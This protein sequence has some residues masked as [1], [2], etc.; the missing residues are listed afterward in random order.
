MQFQASTLLSILSVLALAAAQSSSVPVT[1][2]AGF[3]PNPS[4]S[5]PASSTPATTSTATAT[6]AASSDASSAS[7]AT[8]S[9]SSG[10]A[11]APTAALLD[12]GVVVG[13]VGLAGMML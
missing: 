12:T 10:A 8:S 5:A 4:S 2:S 1:S 7:G 3:S 9:V 6:V 13:L 11:A